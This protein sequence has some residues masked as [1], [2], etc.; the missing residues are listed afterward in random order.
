MPKVRGLPCVCR[1]AALPG[2]DDH[3]LWTL[4]TKSGWEANERVPKH[5]DR[6]KRDHK[7]TAMQTL[8]KTIIRL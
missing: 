2:K 5:I 4:G 6:T 1:D 7:K 3:G 8:Q